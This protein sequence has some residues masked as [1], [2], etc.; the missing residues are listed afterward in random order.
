MKNAI[1]SPL[2]SICIPTYNRVEKLERA[3]RSALNST[4]ANIEIIISDN[5]STDRTQ[6]ICE[7]LQASDGRISY[8]RQQDNIGATK[9]FEFARSLANG[10]YF[11]WLSDD[12]FIERS[13][14]LSC[15]NKLEYDKDLALVS[16]R[17]IFIKN[18][19]S[20]SHESNTKRLIHRNSTVRV[21]KYIWRVGDNSGFYGV[22]R[23]ELVEAI[24]LPNILAGDWVFI[25]NVLQFG[26]YDIANDTVLY[27]EF[28][29]TMSSSGR[30]LVA[31][32][33]APTWQGRFIWLTKAINIARNVPYYG[34]VRKRKVLLRI[35]VRIAVFLL[36]LAKESE[37]TLRRYLSRV[38]FIRKFY[39]VY[40]AAPTKQ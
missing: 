21:A 35:A 2:V 13:Y 29:G 24:D 1:H 15:V 9:N 5:A 27:R 16:G 26:K 36:V 12:D 32:I 7:A 23:R 38:G 30:T 22:Y 31:S 40:F 39:D 10:K 11:M 8:Y 4:Y 17:I 33:G 19:R 6:W 20:K 18:D 25:A 14:I 34:Q 3:V 28:E 37:N